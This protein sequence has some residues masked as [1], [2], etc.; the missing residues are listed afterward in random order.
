MRRM[1]RALVLVLS[2]LMLFTAACSKQD[3]TKDRSR[4][5][6]TVTPVEVTPTGEAT[7]TPEVSPEVTA[8]PEATATPEVTPEA[9]PTAEPTETPAVFNPPDPGCKIEFPT[10]EL[11]HYDM[12][13]RL[14]PDKQTVSGHVVFEFYNDTDAVWDKLC[15]RDYPSLFID[16]EHA[17][18]NS[19]TKLDG[20]LTEIKN[21][22]D[23]RDNSIL[24]CERETDVSVLWLTLV[25]P[26]QPKEKMTLTYDFTA[27]I[28]SLADRF[29][30]SNGVFNVT[31]F[32][33]ILAEYDKNGWSHAG[34][35]N[36]GECFYSEVSNYD[37][38]LTVPNGYLVASTGTETGHTAGGDGVTY[39]YKAPCVRD[40]VFSASEQFG[41]VTENV[42]GVRVNV[43]YNKDNPPSEDMDEALKA[44]VKAAKDSLAAF[45]EAFG[46][47]P[48]EEL[49]IILT[50]IFAGGMEYPN[51]IIIADSLAQPYMTFTGPDYSDL[52]TCIAHEIGHQ[53]FMGIVGSN[54]GMQ[55]WQDE[56]ITSYSELVYLEYL[57]D[58]GIY[59]EYNS[60][61]YAD[62]SLKDVADKLAEQDLLPVNRSYYEFSNSSR[63]VTAIYSVGEMVLYQIEETIGRQE[64]HSVLREYV[65]RNAFTNADPESFFEVLYECAGKDNEDLNALIANC[66][67]R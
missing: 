30:V 2:V 43:L 5:E 3:Q 31:N 41:I 27:T 51:L 66:F 13:L 64:M 56:S 29:G 46:C 60:R 36:V 25:K 38:K 26:L 45:G 19:G 49:D 39:T 53:W 16:A 47:Y 12:D 52:E 59:G 35:Y 15:M 23:G 40:F 67:I 32:Y 44:S 28:P 22:V 10:R 33:P 65:H 11:Y 61:E 8:T 21:I 20:A 9:T 1:R 18:M 37:V 54:S 6:T 4:K 7:A 63:Y 24:A 42:S 57:G 17:D 14:D 48:Y 55:P 62:L 58:L 50:P 34:F